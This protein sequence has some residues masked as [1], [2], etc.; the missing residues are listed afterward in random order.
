MPL[1]NLQQLLD[2]SQYDGMRVSES[3]IM[4][5]W[6][7]L[8]G[9][10]ISKIEF[11]ARLGEGSDPLPEWSDDDKANHKYQTAKRADAIVWFDQ[12]PVILELKQR[13]VA[14]AVG[15][16]LSYRHFFMEMYP[17]ALEPKMRAV[18]RWTDQDVMRV[19]S[20]YGIDVE[21][22]PR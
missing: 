18:C 22:I 11:Y 14:A 17:D 4:R 3:Y 15:Q 10:E 8:H 1:P 21:V 20:S 9:A 6:L 2:K 5:D 12:Q 16:I 7:K 19:M 13:L